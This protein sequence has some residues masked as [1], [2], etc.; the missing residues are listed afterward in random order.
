MDSSRACSDTANH[1]AW[2]HCSVNGVTGM[3][4]GEIGEDVSFAGA[5][6]YIEIDYGDCL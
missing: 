5:V 4:D 2:S 3:L 6:G 1:R